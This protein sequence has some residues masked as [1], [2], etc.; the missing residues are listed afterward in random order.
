M[1]VVHRHLSSP[2][3]VPL[4]AQEDGGRTGPPFAQADRLQEPSRD[5]KGLP[6]AHAV[7]NYVRIGPRYVIAQA[8]VLLQNKKDVSWYAIEVG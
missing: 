7:H 6:L 8:A 2:L 4:V 5:I 1:S 3:Q